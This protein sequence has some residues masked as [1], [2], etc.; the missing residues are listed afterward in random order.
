MAEQH[1]CNPST[2][3]PDT[4]TII[5]PN[6]T[7]YLLT[8]LLLNKILFLCTPVALDIYCSWQNHCEDN[9]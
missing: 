2:V 1:T 7:L 8:L 9:H 6:H 4:Q 5:T 3:S